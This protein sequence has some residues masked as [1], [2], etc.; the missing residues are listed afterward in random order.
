MGLA[1]RVFHLADQMGFAN[2]S[3]DCNPIHVDAVQARRTQAGA[4][5][6]HGIHL[7]LWA[8]DAFAAHQPELPPI[9]GVRAQF[10]KYIYLGEPVELVLN[11]QKPSSVRLSLCVDGVARTKLVIDIG[12]ITGKGPDW[13]DVPCRPVPY[14]ATP[15]D[16]PFDQFADYSGRLD[17]HM[18]AETAL[19]LF[20]AASRWFGVRRIAALAASTYLVG[21]VCPGLHSIYSQISISGCDFPTRDFLDFRVTNSDPSFRLVDLE[22]VGGGISGMVNSFARQP[23]V[24]QLSMLSLK[25][26]VTADEFAGS[27]ALIVGGSRG[28]GELT[29]KLIAAGG[30]RVLIT[31]Q[32]GKEDAER[33]AE[34]IRA[35]GGL[36]ETLHYDACKPASEQLSTLTEA[37]S[38]AYYFATPAIFKPQAGVFSSE[39]FHEFFDVYVHGFWQLMQA[40]LARQLRLSAFYPSS[41]AVAERPKGMT[42]YTMAKAA[43][44]VLCADLNKALSPSHVTISQLP[45]LATDQTASV[46]AVETADPLETMLPIVREVQSWP[47]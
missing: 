25:G 5:V 10:Y 45:R 41:V 27:L 3:G 7:L 24:A 35:A 38:H 36:C 4:P 8:L 32:S 18:T 11:L 15:L 39:R 21:M 31:W 6:V 30:G 28:L 44:E 14:K 17:L 2:A 1:K 29:A 16:L 9:C 22:I 33:V 46:T 42:E 20:P 23:P 40:L 26:S 12:E 47:R 37:P 13:T 43:G 19:S 34:E